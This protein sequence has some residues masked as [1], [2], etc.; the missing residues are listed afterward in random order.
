MSIDVSCAFATQIA[1]PEHARIAESLG[2]KRAWF[3]DSPALYPDVWVQLCRAAERTSTIGLGTGV[4]IPDLRHPMTTAAAIATLVDAA[5]QDRV[6]IG[7]GSGFTGRYALGQKPHKWAFVVEYVKAVKGLLRGDVVTWQGG[8]MKMLHPEG[9]GPARPI[10]VPFVLG[11]AG[12]KGFAAVKEVGDGAF[13]AG[14]APQPDIDWQIAL[15]FGTVLADGESPDSERVMAAA[16]HGVAVLLHFMSEVGFPM[17]GVP[18][19]PEWVAAYADLPADERH[20]AIHDLHLVGVNERDRPLI[21]G[22]FIRQQGGCYT[23]DQLREALATFESNGVTEVA[24]QPAG[25]DIPR[26]LEAF[27]TAATG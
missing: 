16:G 9:F 25:P 13:V 1:S 23:P 20:L 22:E 11:A 17:D 8:K 5:G 3:Y 15:Q 7:V 4:L 24:Y 27:I 21:T 2:Y 19:G 10:T 6:A 26:E 12:P 14:A 18:G